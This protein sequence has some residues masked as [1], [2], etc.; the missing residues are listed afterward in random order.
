M[1]KVNPS[2]TVTLISGAGN[3]KA[4]SNG[5]GNATKGGGGKSSL[6]PIPTKNKPTR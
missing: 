4:K 2:G 6:R 1:A 5:S 3:G